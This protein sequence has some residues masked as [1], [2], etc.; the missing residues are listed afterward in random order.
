M[1]SLEFVSWDSL[2]LT[3]VARVKAVVDSSSTDTTRDGLIGDLIT[4]VS[5]QFTNYIGNHMLEATRTETYEI[6]Q[7]ARMMTLDASPVRTGAG[8]VTS[9]WYDYHPSELTISDALEA[10]DYSVH[11]GAGWIR[12][13]RQLQYDPGYIQIVY[14]AGMATATSNTTDDSGVLERYPDLAHMCDLQV[15]YLLER[16]KTLGGSITT[17]PGAKASFVGEY[18]FLRQVRKHLDSIRRVRH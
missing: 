8:G 13:H 15:K 12:F 2:D 7:N 1:T 9:I 10:K 17:I 3:T 5:K 11:N 14:T 6:K 16:L 18:G 4:E